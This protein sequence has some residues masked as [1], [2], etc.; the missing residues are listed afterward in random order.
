M[1][2]L[3]MGMDVKQAAISGLTGGAILAAFTLPDFLLIF[4][5]LGAA[6]GAGAAMMGYI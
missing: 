6:I 3:K 1:K 4:A 2:V 5:F